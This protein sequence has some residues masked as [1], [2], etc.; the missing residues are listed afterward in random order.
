MR[1]RTLT[2]TGPFTNDEF[3]EVV[4]L[5]R[6]IDQRHP[7][8]RFGIFMDDPMGGADEALEAVKLAL[9]DAPGRVTV[10]KTF[11]MPGNVG[12]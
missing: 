7:G 3:A 4:A 11:P 8:H 12:C 1:I 5:I 10:I 2:V 6:E 9:P